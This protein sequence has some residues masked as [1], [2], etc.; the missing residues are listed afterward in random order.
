MVVPFMLYQLCVEIFVISLTTCTLSKPATR[1]RVITSSSGRCYNN[2][3]RILT[4]A[5][6]AGNELNKDSNTERAGKKQSARILT[7]PNT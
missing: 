4:F 6:K 5:L 1:T 7:L 3:S 2:V